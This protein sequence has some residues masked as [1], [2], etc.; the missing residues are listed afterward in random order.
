MNRES[1]STAEG[2]DLIAENRALKAEVEQLRGQLARHERWIAVGSTVGTGGWSLAKR[3]LVGPE[4]GRAI[5]AAWDRTAE[6]LR[7]D[8]SD[9]PHTAL[10]DVVAA[11]ARRYL[12][13]VTVLGCL[14]A[15]IGVFVAIVTPWLMYRQLRLLEQQNALLTHQ[16]TIVGNQTELMRR[17]TASAEA[18]GSVAL[19]QQMRE[20]RSELS[21][22]RPVVQLQRSL[23][24]SIGTARTGPCEPNCDATVAA[25]TQE[26]RQKRVPQTWLH[27]LATTTAGD[28]GVDPREVEVTVQSCGIPLQQV[29]AMWAKARALDQVA[30]EMNTYAAQLRKL[31]ELGDEGAGSINF[32]ATASAIERTCETLTQDLGPR[33]LNP[34]TI[35]MRDVRDGFDRLRADAQRSATIVRER[36]EAAARSLAPRAGLDSPE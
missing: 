24:A 14:P 1:S 12:F 15:L 2:P 27:F 32:A 22:L 34:S 17:Q 10:R 3:I 9:P 25:F 23:E 19:S 30:R 13:R 29:Q 7:G 11:A 26:V 21:A 31:S 8:A 20:A 5:A 6:Y 16:N 28:G 33:P 18:Q 35:R 36:C 4:L